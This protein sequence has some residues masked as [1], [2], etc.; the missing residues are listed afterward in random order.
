[1]AR[2]VGVLGSSFEACRAAL[3]IVDATADRPHLEVE[4]VADRDPYAYPPLLPFVVA[5]DLAPNHASFSASGLLPEEVTVRIGNIERFDPQSGSLTVD[6][7]PVEFD[8]LLL[9]PAAQRP[10]DTASHHLDTVRAAVELRE[11]LREEGNDPVDIRGATLSAVETSAELAAAG[12]TTRPVRLSAGRS[13]LTPDVPAAAR[14]AIRDR[15]RELGVDLA[16]DGGG[17]PD[18]P[19]SV[20]IDCRPGVAP[21]WLRR[22]EMCDEGGRFAVDAH[23]G[24]LAADRIFG[25]GPVAIRPEAGG[26]RDAVRPVDRYPSEPGRLAARNLLAELAGRSLRRWESGASGW[27]VA[28]GGGDGIVDWQGLQLDGRIGGIAH[29]VV[30]ARRLPTARARAAVITDT[31]DFRGG[32]DEALDHLDRLVTRS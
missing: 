25:A 28:A 2:T 6:G 23:L 10:A 16:L 18:S 1:M 31:I 24:A 32:V 20:V 8:Y 13:N 9:A 15:L 11:H 5:G 4:I 12:E 30:H 3:E 21:D 29:R 19:A 27:A 17:E 26:G 7:E 14:D 22:A